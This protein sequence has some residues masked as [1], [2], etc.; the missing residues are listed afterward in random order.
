MMQWSFDPAGFK[1][2]DHFAKAF[3][4][5]ENSLTVKLG[6]FGF[7]RHILPDELVNTYFGTPLYMAPEI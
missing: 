7:A 5:K 2:L 1:T 4:I 3:H 6:D